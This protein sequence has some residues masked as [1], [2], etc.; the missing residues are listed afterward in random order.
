MRE[1]VRLRLL[2]DR[3]DRLL[4]PARAAEVERHLA[5][6]CAECTEGAA[7]LDRALVALAEGP[8][9][10]PPRAV[11]RDAVRLF[12]AAKW[13]HLLAIPGRIVAQ[14]VFDQRL[15]VVPALRASGG[16]TRR[17]LWNVGRHELDA[18][19]VERRLDND[20]AGQILPETDDGTSPVVGEVHAVRSGRTVAFA[21]LDADGRFSFPRL[22]HGTY[23][24]VGRV[25][26]E[27]FVVAPI[28]LGEPA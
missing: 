23:A 22:P 3:R 8:L 17:M 18:S 12:R 16:G 13:A 9:P 1:H 11:V 27:E 7:R 26:G 20:L 19:I 2:A 25:G 21:T 15:D 4:S 14:L 10:E 24:L 28:P 6:G 5:T